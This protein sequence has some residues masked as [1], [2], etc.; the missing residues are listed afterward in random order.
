MTAP[1]PIPTLVRE[2]LVDQLGVALERVTDDARLVEHLGADSLDSQKKGRKRVEPPAVGERFGLLTVTGP[3]SYVVGHAVAPCRCDCG[4]E[5]LSVVATMRSGRLRSCGCLRKKTAVEAL[6]KATVKHGQAR[7]GQ[8]TPEFR[9]WTGMLARCSNPNVAGYKHYGGRGIA[10]CERWR[11]FANFFEDMG[12][13]PSPAHSIDRYPNNDG[14]YEPGNCRWATPSEQAR[15]KRPGYRVR[16]ECD[17]E[18]LTAHEWSLRS[19]V[20]ERLIRARVREGWD[21]RRAIFQAPDR[22]RQP[23]L[24]A[25]ENAQLAQAGLR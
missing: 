9:I 23:K 18:K 15:N 12:P 2:V 11:S 8:M 17:G 1:K 22:T 19:G 4:T 20:P 24:L 16:I 5:R 14:D 13:R 7:S 10:V 6:R 21:A 25:A 3:T